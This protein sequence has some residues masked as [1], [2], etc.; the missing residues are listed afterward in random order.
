M[1]VVNGVMM[2]Y[3]E[4]YITAEQ[5]L[6]NQ[7]KTQA[8]EL[9]DA[10]FTAMWLPPAYKG[11]GGT[12]DVGYAVYD[13]YDLGEFNQ[14]GTVRTKYGTRQEYLDAIAALK[15]NGLQVYADVV[16]NHRMGADGTEVMKATPF[17]PGDRTHPKGGP[18][19]IRAYTH[20]HFP[21]RNGQHSDFEWH[22]WHF[23]AV[24]WDDI[25]KE[26]NTIYLLEGKQFDDYVALEN[27]TLHT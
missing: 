18:R 22:W 20:F 5:N 6:W 27:A 4:W 26:S 2:Q 14:Q 12:F 23:D 21:G 25:S 8:K 17:H 19:D 3:F 1:S 16:L 15:S 11:M 24:D 9:A 10:G 13:M 7:V